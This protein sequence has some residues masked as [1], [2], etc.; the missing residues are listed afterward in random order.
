VSIVCD[1]IAPLPQPYMTYDRLG[2]VCSPELI[3]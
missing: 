1:Q 2:I 3:R